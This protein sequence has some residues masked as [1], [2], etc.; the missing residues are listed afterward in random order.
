MRFETFI[1]VVDQRPSYSIIAL[2]AP[3]AIST[4]PRPA[5]E[6]ATARR[7]PSWAGVAL[8]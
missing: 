7:G 2:N 5:V 4:R 1:D 6:H 8:P 3:V